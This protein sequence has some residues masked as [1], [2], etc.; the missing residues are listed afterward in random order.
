LYGVKYKG[1]R[2]RNDN[3]VDKQKIVL[4]FY[5]GGKS[6]RAIQRETGVCRKTIRKHISEY[7]SN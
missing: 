4:K 1:V 6:Q 3:L 5:Y 7:E 2:G